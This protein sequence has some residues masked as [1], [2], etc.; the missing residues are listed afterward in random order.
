M[1]STSEIPS[2]QIKVASLCYYKVSFFIP[3]IAICKYGCN[4]DMKILVKKLSIICVE[5]YW[6]ISIISHNRLTLS[7][8]SLAPCFPTPSKLVHHFELFYIFYKNPV[9]ILQNYHL[10]NLPYNC[11][12]N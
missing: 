2:S 3:T 12:N 7:H 1:A 8:S 9:A 4:L 6:P 10:G 11:Y 5:D